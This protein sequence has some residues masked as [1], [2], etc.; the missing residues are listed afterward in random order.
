MSLRRHGP[1][2]LED[3]LVTIWMASI[4]SPMSELWESTS[5]SEVMCRF[6]ITTMWTGQNG[7]V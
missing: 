5:S 2:L 6:G 7:R 3:L 4:R 1:M